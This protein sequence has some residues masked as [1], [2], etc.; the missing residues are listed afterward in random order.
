MLVGYER[1]Q[2]SKMKVWQE[3]QAAHE[4]AT[5]ATIGRLQSIL[6]AWSQQHG[7]QEP[8]VEQTRELL[9]LTEPLTFDPVGDA[10]YTDPTNGVTVRLWFRD[11]TF[12]TG[13]LRSTKPSAARH[14]GN[15]PK[16]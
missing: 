4:Q 1:Y 11:Q 10:W 2:A 7:G 9:G 5:L 14:N 8:D 16:P 3:V 15:S 12:W 6:S 13:V